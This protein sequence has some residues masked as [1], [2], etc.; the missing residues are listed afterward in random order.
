MKGGQ[1]PSDR[2]PEQ[3]RL[4]LK[5]VD[6]GDS[7]E[8]LL[9]AAILT[10]LGLRGFLTLTGYPMF[11]PLGLHIAHVLWG[12]ILMLAAT[13]LLL[14]YWNPSIRRLAAAIAG[15]GFGA[16]IDELGKFITQD[17]DYFYRPAIALIYFIFVLLFLFLRSIRRRRSLGHAE[18]V[19]NREIREYSRETEPRY[20]KVSMGY[21][22][23]RDWVDSGYRKI[24]LHPLFRALLIIGFVALGVSEMTQTG[25]VIVTGTPFRETGVTAIQTASSLISALLILIGILK[26]KYSRL[27][28]YKWFQRSVLVS[29]LIT[30]V[31]VFYES[32]LSGLGG[33]LLHVL[34]YAALRYVIYQEEEKLGC[35]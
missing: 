9:I 22:K 23:L 28:A 30:Q 17:H 5:D 14:N 7:I 16:F 18:K 10:I 15:V 12:G 11:S 6:A 3:K 24:T 21:F 4:L 34:V 13:I 32:Q 29:I 2:R 33:L 8:L 35:V 25:I 19:L 20:D 1:R 31:F 26:L 27:D